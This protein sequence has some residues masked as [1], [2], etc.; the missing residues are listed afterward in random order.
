MRVLG[1]LGTLAVL[2]SGAALAQSAAPHERLEGPTLPEYVVG[3]RGGNAEQAIREEVPRGETVQRW[4]RMVT[5]QWLAGLSSRISAVD[6]AALMV[7]DFPRS[8]PGG[9]VTAPR[10]LTISGRPAALVR[11]DCPLL[12]ETNRPETFIMLIVA[13]EKDLLVRQVAF[14]SVPTAEDIDWADAVLSGSVWCKAGN[15]EP[16]CDRI[17]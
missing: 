11:A 16:P 17:D 10:E 2:F 4:T 8:C 3:F 5:T 7:R 15:D 1:K 6:F 9:K 13:G 14:R 12:R